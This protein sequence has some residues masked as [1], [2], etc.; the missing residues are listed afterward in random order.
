M[1]YKVLSYLDWLKKQTKKRVYTKN[2][3]NKRNFTMIYYLPIDDG[4]EE[5]VCK[6][7]FKNIFCISFVLLLPFC[8][9]DGRI[10][11]IL[12]FKSISTTPPIDQR[13]KHIPHNKTS[14]LKIQAV[15]D[16]ISR[17]PSYESH[18]S[19]E[20]SVNRKY[21][22]PDLNIKC[23]YK[24]YKEQIQEPVS[25]FYFSRYFQYKI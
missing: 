18:Y 9:S 16:F 25:F 23:M 21:L 17:F 22:A 11:R 4:K 7:F 20:K 12:A 24:L 15:K 19:R 14:D 1:I 8:I 13:G 6:S 5:N 2:V 3:D 10:S